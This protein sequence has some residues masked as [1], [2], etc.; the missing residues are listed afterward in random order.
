MISIRSASG[1]EHVG[2]FEPV[3]DY[4]FASGLN[5]VLSFVTALVPESKTR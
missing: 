4:G 5:V 1:P 2:L 3:A